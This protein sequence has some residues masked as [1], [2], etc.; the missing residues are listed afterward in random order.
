MLRTPTNA[1]RRRVAAHACPCCRRLW[2]LSG[3]RIPSGS[4]VIACKFCGWHAIRGG[5]RRPA[6][7]TGGASSRAD[8]GTDWSHRVLF[9]A[10]DDHLMGAVE[11]YLV[12]GWEAGGV[13]LVIATPQHRTA[14]RDRLAAHGVLDSLGQGRYVELDAAAT[15]EQ[16]MGDDGVPDPE[17]FATTVGSLV[18]DHAADRT[19]RGFGEMVDLLWAGGNAVG[20]LELERLWSGLQDEVPFALLCAYAESHVDEDDRVEIARV[21]DHVTA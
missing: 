18:R 8:A 2:A 5:P 6:P 1:A 11:D 13:G 4:W 9:H 3:S 19:L 17:R 15:L 7:G 16:F 14:L 12:A 20:A 21:H 10:G